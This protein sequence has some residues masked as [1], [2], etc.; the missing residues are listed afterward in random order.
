ME[1]RFHKKVLFVLRG[2]QVQG[3]SY[4]IMGFPALRAR[5]KHELVASAFLFFTDLLHGPV[6]KNLG[7]NKSQHL[8]GLFDSF[9][10]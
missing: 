3:G 1:N 5:T 7:M 10:F 6:L 8:P 4:C 9:S 2:E